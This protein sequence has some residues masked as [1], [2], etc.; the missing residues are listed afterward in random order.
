M[1][2]ARNN[3]QNSYL[4]VP[5]NMKKTIEMI[6][7]NVTIERAIDGTSLY[8]TAFEIHLALCLINENKESD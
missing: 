8:E 1:N 2:E 5:A 6:V 3:S 4:N 7:K